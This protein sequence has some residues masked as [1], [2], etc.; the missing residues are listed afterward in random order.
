MRIVK[1]GV[2]AVALAAMAVTGV[3]PAVAD[4][5]IPGTP[6]ETITIDINL[7]GCSIGAGLGGEVLAALTAGTG[8]TT[9]VG[10]GLAT[11]LRA[12]GCLPF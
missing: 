5:G 12:A 1:A 2:V 7:L 11:R 3:G 10:A 9:A 8:S 6:E 4:E